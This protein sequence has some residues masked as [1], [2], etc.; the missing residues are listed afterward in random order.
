[1]ACRAW[2][3]LISRCFISLDTSVDASSTCAV[4][5]GSKGVQVHVHV[6]HMI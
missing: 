4:V 5:E 2:L 1:V 6:H 3:P